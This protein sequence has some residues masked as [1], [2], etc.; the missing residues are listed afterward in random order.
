MVNADNHMTITRLDFCLLLAHSLPLE[1]CTHTTVFLVKCMGCLSLNISQQS[2]SVSEA[3]FFLQ[4]IPMGDTA[5]ALPQVSVP[6]LS[7]LES[8]INVSLLSTLQCDFL[9]QGLEQKSEWFRSC[10]W[11]YQSVSSSPMNSFILV[12]R[13]LCVS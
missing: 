6:F 8:K 11:K 5:T 9:F 2:P 7:P 1:L 4:V 12:L 10:V 3:S 13:M